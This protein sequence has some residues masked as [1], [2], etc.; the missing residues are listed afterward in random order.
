M[1]VPDAGE[2][3]LEGQTGCGKGAC[4]EIVQGADLQMKNHLGENR[5]VQETA[6]GSERRRGSAAQTAVVEHEDWRRGTAQSLR[7]EKMGM[8][9]K[10]H[11]WEIQEREQRLSYK[12]L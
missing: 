2:V 1:I 11:W 12:I 9:L 10:G 3:G 8:F 7:K 6:I 4:S 5:K